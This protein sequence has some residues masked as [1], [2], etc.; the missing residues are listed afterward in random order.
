MFDMYTLKEMFTDLGYIK[1]MLLF[2]QFNI[3]RQSLDESLLPL[4]SEEDLIIL[5]E[6]VLRFRKVEVYIET[7]VSLVEK[8]MMERMRS[9]GKAVLIEEIMDDYVNDVVG[10]DLDA[11]VE[12]VVE[13][14]CLFNI[15]GVSHEV[16][17]LRIFPITLTE[18]AKRWV[19]R[20]SPGTVDSWD[21]LKKAFIQRSS[22]NEAKARTIELKL[23]ISSEDNSASISGKSRDVPTWFND[24]DVD[25]GI[26][27]KWKDDPYHNVDEPEESSVMFA[28]LDKALDKLNQVIK[29]QEVSNLFVFYDQP[30]D[31]E[32]GVVPYKVVDEEIVT[33]SNL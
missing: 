29:A 1:G 21:L 4:I 24:E 8:H 10:K 12:T 13:Y 32:G 7:G 15:P 11:N 9:K 30:I 3:P 23:G 16:V 6:Y 28:N 5:L 31:D 17:M 27:V 20:L 14:H 18:D 25:Q 19:D 2:I 33:P 22:P 26:D